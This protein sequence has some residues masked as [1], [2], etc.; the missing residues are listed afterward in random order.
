MNSHYYQET[1]Y[2]LSDENVLNNK[3]EN[4][5]STNPKLV[6]G[7]VSRTRRL[8]MNELSK[9][10]KFNYETLTA[11]IDEKSIR[12]EDANDLV[13]ALGYAKSKAIINKGFNN[14]YLIT[15]DQVNFQIELN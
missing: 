13:M 12:K 10:F 5:I 14:G 9:E 4:F 1:K 3:F 15:C 6:L 11:G 2:D 7:S 8:V